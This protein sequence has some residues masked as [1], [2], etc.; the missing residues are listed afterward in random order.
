MLCKVGGAFFFSFA[1]LLVLIEWGGWGCA[2][3]EGVM[4]AADGGEALVW[5]FSLFL[6][7]LGLLLFSLLRF[8]LRSRMLGEMERELKRLIR[9]VCCLLLDTDETTGMAWR[10]QGD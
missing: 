1:G 4:V 3:A 2:K 8:L 6:I 9:G 5:S 7:L 10:C